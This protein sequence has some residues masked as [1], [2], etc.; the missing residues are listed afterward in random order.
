MGKETF[1]KGPTDRSGT[2]ISLPVH[3]N[4]MCSRV[5]RYKLTLAYRGTRYHG[6]QEQVYCP[7][8][9]G[10]IPEDGS[11]LPTIQST[12]TAALRDVL[13]HDLELCGSSRT[14]AG[15]HAKGQVA[16]FDTS[17]IQ[18]P[19]EGLRRAV[20]ARLPDDIVIRS[21]E[22]VDPTFDAV[23][24]T[25][26]KRYQYLIWNDA[27]KPVF[28]WDLAFH[29]WQKLNI[30]AMQQAASFL[31]GEHDFA[32]F[33]KP[34]HGRTSTVRTIH[35]L[36]IHVRRPRVVIGI[37]GNGFLWNMVRIIVGTLI[38]VGVG[39]IDP[40][41]I[42][43]ILSSRDRRRAGKTAPAHGLYLHWIRYRNP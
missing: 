39:Q 33:S 8:W 21:I 37:T 6:W 41:D 18:I 20:N 29:R 36:S 22:P 13:K 42:P 31:I 16:H 28:H 12:V 5:Q 10:P 38:D 11:G 43:D 26:R 4:R 25:D 17:M 40:T 19:P 24:L 30:P 23:S 7:T 2:K 1:P 14:D 9:K 3:W 27:D 34:G 35:E 32:A 15:V